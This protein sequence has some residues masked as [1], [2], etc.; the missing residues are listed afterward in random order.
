MSLP[1]SVTTSVLYR[2]SLFSL[3]I[4]IWAMTM[5]EPRSLMA[6]FGTTTGAGM[7]SSVA[8]ALGVI[9]VIDVIINDILPERFQWQAAKHH[10]H[11][12]LVALAFCYVAQLY[13]A[14]TAF[15]SLELN[16]FYCWNA[17]SLL[18]LALVDAHQRN[19]RPAKDRR[20]ANRRFS[21]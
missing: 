13:I 12:I 11:M 14:F 8:G 15:K 10:R 4:V 7:L 2:L 21:L 9:G 17:T 16:V 20:N 19:P 3:A 1:N 6:Q 18:S 5:L